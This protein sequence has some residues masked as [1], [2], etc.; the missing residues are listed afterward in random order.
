MNRD[1]MN[2][3]SH[4]LQ[5]DY[6]VKATVIS[7]T[8]L[9]MGSGL[10]AMD[11]IFAY[12]G[13]P[14][15]HASLGAAPNLGWQLLKAVRENNEAKVK[16]IIELGAD[17]NFE[18]LNQHQP[19]ILAAQDGKLPIVKT[20]LEHNADINAQ[21]A[22]DITA[23]WMAAYYGHLDIVRLLLDK[24]ASI[25]RATK[26][27]ATPL[28]V[29]AQNNHLD[30]VKTLL[31]HGAKAN[32]RTAET[33]YTALMQAADRDHLEIVHALLTT[34][35]DADA[36]AYL[37]LAGSMKKNR[38][39]RTSLDTRRL[40]LHSFLDALIQKKMIQVLDMIAL[41]N[42]DRKTARDLALERHRQAIADLLDI[43][44]PE[45]REKIRAM[46][47]EGVKQA[48]RSQA[49]R[50]Y[51]NSRGISWDEMFGEF[52][53]RE[54][55]P[56]M[57]KS[58]LN[59]QLIRAANMGNAQQVKQ[60]L[61]NGAD[62]NARDSSR[63]DRTALLMAHGSGLHSFKKVCEL[64]IAHGAD[65]NARDKDDKTALIIA[66]RDG[67]REVCILLIAHGADL[68]A[69]DNDGWT[70]LMNAAQY[71][72]KGI[73]KLLINAM[74]KPSNAQKNLVVALLGSLKKTAGSQHLQKDTKRLIAQTKLDEYK[75]QNKS[76]AETEIK[77]I[78]NAELKQELL[79]YLKSLK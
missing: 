66:A 78:D 43:S 46:V 47:A 44:T 32:I 26:D 67:D 4:S 71:G 40:V 51:P 35:P 5:R 49:A 39:L 28:F 63:A 10:Q 37:T 25:N 59:L 9:M 48:I 8:I 2:P 18:G 77:R 79:E 50:K 57:N 7:L 3:P 75:Q 17:V 76:V 53:P 31:A 6:F 65:I 55:E 42:K 16:K 52:E 61:M 15:R 19:L 24:G 36:R 13:L 27:R 58:E 68:H 69:E 72:H 33:N 73:C 41:Q 60:L 29:A 64:L 12:P 23:L 54:E 62:V 22:N 74:V 20:L 38:G 34:I 11:P 30:I 21:S 14:A 45:A 56:V 1:F 70:A